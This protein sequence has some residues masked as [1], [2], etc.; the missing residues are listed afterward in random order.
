MQKGDCLVVPPFAKMIGTKFTN[1]TLNFEYLQ[2]LADIK[3]ISKDDPMIISTI[4]QIKQNKYPTSSNN[5]VIL[6]DKFQIS[7]L[8]NIYFI[9]ENL[10]SIA[11]KKQYSERGRDFLVSYLLTELSNDYL[12]CLA[13]KETNQIS[14]IHKI[15]EWIN[16][17]ISIDLSVQKVAD[18]FELNPSYL[19]RLFKKATNTG[20]KQYITQ[21]KLSHAK[22][23]LL[24]TSMQI[25]QIALKCGFSNAK[26]FDHVF[27]QY[28]KLSP[29]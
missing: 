14:K 22:Y 21:A 20:V 17:N 11:N 4:L 9:F 7:N 28:N 3:E 25:N 10:L 29:T 27:K 5:Y 1:E 18:Q 2:V 15:I 13:Q 23:L 6:P 8:N 19:S 16:I 26:L 12:S 24:T